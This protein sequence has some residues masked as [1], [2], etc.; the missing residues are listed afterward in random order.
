MSPELWSKRV[1]DLGAPETAQILQELLPNTKRSRSGDAGEI[2]ATEVAEEKLCYEVPIRRLRWKDGR[3]AALRGDDIVGVAND[4]EGKV[5]FLKGEAKSR[6]A[7]SAGTVKEASEALDRDMGGRLVTP[8][9][10]LPTASV[11]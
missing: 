8:Y 10:L 7:L 9:F 6:V 4:A 1:E 11:T 5:R 2:L 3:D